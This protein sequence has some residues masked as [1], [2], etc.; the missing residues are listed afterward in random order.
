MISIVT[1]KCDTANAV[2][3]SAKLNKSTDYNQHMTAGLLKSCRLPKA[4]TSVMTEEWRKI[5]AGDWL[6]VNF[7]CGINVRAEIINEKLENWRINISGRREISIE[8]SFTQ[9]NRKIEKINCKDVSLMKA[10]VGEMSK[11]CSVF[12]SIQRIMSIM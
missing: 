6:N 10:V 4:V 5:I 9:I 8:I 11:K 2:R 12:D 7:L 3:K 1:G